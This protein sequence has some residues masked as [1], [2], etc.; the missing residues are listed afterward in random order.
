M[1]PDNSNIIIVPKQQN[2][3]FGELFEIQSNVEEI[4]VNGATVDDI[5]IV[6]FINIAELSLN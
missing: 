3:K 1:A 6:E 5:E 4:F 2:Q